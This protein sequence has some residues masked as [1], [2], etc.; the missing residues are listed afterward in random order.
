MQFDVASSSKLHNSSCLGCPKARQYI[1][2]MRRKRASR[3]MSLL[4]GSAALQDW[5]FAWPGNTHHGRKSPMT[6]L[7]SSGLAATAAS[8][9]ADHGFASSDVVSEE[10]NADAT[11]FHTA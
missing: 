3:S 5:V 8:K 9:R 1:P 2:R 11:I 4:N 6:S 10:Q 7:T